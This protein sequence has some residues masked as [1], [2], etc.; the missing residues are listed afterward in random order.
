MIENYKRFIE[1]Y[2]RFGI[3]NTI[4]SLF[5]KIG[6]KVNLND[7]IQKKKIY[8][9]KK[10]HELCKGEVVDGVFKGAKFI[11]TSSYNTVKPAQLL[12]CYEK[13]VQ[14]KIFELSKKII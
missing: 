2:K 8:L 9:S 4:K 3:I 12:G 10:M 6:I 5:S 11:Y 7:T 14:E 13:E 1:N